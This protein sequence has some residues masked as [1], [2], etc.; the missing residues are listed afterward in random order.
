MKSIAITTFQDRFYN[1]ERHDGGGMG[2]G[3]GRE[4]NRRDRIKKEGGEVI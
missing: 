4:G 3:E 1:C 2:S